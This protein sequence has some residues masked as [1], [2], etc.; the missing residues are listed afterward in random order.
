[1]PHGTSLASVVVITVYV[2]VFGYFMIVYNL[3]HYLQ[4]FV[5]KVVKVERKETSSYM[6]MFKNLTTVCNFKSI[7]ERVL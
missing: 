3:L 1:M 5:R 7:S 4:N 6:H 2:Y